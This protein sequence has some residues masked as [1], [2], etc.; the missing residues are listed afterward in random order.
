MNSIEVESTNLKY[1]IIYSLLALSILVSLYLIIRKFISDQAS[2]RSLTNND[3]RIIPMQNINNI[4]EAPIIPNIA[5][6]ILVDR[7][8]EDLVILEGNVIN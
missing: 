1:S 7:L 3:A 2:I 4:P 8:D 6:G 5:N